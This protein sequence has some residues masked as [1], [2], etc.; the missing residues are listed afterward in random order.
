[1]NMQN[2]TQITE[3]RLSDEIHGLDQRIAE[4]A[5][6]SSSAQRCVSSYLKQLAKTKRDQL[7]ALRYQRQ[8]TTA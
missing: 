8:L 4:T 7:A 2:Y 3:D 1:M 5:D 6:A